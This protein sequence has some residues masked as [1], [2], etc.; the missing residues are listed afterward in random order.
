[1]FSLVGLPPLAGFAAKF[2]IF[3][4]VFDAR[5]LVLLAIGVLNTVLSLFYYLRVVKVM[6]ITPEPDERQAPRI[7]LWS[8]A[9]LYC[10]GITTPLV[11]LGILWNDLFDWAR[12]AASA[13]VYY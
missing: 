5:L 3:A 10:L 9:G 12:A 8:L 2:T 1:L 6:I 13:L 11:V 4:A 7:P